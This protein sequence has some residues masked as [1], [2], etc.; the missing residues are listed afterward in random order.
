MKRKLIKQGGGGLTFYVPKKWTDLNKLEPGDELEIQE[1]D[2]KLLVNVSGKKKQ[3]KATTITL[4]PGHYNEFRSIIGG[5]Y[6]EGY[7]LIRVKYN[8]SKVLDELQKT[9][10]SL[11]GFEVFDMDEKSCTIKGIYQE[12]ATEVKAHFKRIIHSL[13]V[14]QSTIGEDI[15]KKEFDSKREILQYRNNVL[16]QR[17]IITRTIVQRKL[18]TKEHFPY[19]QMSFNLWNIAR[20]YNFIYLHLIRKKKISKQ[21]LKFLKETEK[22]F[23]DTF[24]DTKKVNTLVT[25]RK[26]IENLKNGIGLMEGKNNSLV[27]SYCLNILQLIQACNSQILLLNH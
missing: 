24:H 14:M 27:I 10:D 22:L 11:Y 9:V 18:L 2:N 15:E 13:N 26:Y 12:E 23:N 17:D 4:E 21:S 5:L 3:P 25:H 6:R 1:E 20:N 8:D 7:D 19:Y 16:K